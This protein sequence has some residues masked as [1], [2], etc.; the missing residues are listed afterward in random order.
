MI[1]DLSKEIIQK[2]AENKIITDWVAKVGAVPNISVNKV[3]SATYPAIAVYEIQS[4]DGDYADDEVESSILTYQI[5]LFSHDGS[6]VKIMNEVDRL[7]RKQL[8]FTQRIYGP[9]LF[10]TDTSIIHKP[11]RYT[12][13]KLH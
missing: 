2:L 3:P 1:I 12:Q 5:S 4:N 7:M 6:H 13:N 11:L 8:G 9:N 10:E